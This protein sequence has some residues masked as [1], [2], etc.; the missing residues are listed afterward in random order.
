MYIGIAIATAIAACLVL[1]L[2]SANQRLLAAPWPAWPARAAS[3][4]LAVAS[5]I[6]FAQDLQRLPATFA[7]V[8]VVMLALCVLPYL[9]A[10][11]R[12]EGKR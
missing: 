2:A 11:R 9:G 8:T 7:L 1:Y 4:T 3:A 12:R 5:W 6:A 10:L